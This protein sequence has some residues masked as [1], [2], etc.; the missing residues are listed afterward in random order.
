M[1]LR[2]PVIWRCRSGRP[3]DRRAR[4]ALSILA[5]C[6]VAVATFGA[7]PARGDS[8]AQQADDDAWVETGHEALRKEVGSK[9]W[10]DAEADSLRPVEIE[11]Q[12]DFRPLAWLGRWIAEFIRVAAYALL[13]LLLVGLAWLLI[14]LFL[15]RDAAA[16]RRSTK[17]HK[18]AAAD[19][20]DALPIPLDTDAENLL[21]IAGKLYAQGKYSEAVVY[22][23]SHELV[24]LDRHRHIRLALGKTN[25]QYLRELRGKADLR[26]LLATTIDRFERAFFGRERLDRAALDACWTEIPRFTALVAEESP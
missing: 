12:W 6:A 2:R 23:F 13:T 24:E 21:E 20:V 11:S 18:L 9:H 10:Y 5:A 16:V 26:A 8:P 3:A 4:F 25:R 22:L 1:T 19:R 15:Q 7:P 14:R 17:S